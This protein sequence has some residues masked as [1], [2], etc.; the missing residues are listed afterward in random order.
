VFDEDILNIYIDSVG[1]FRQPCPN[2]TFS[3]LWTGLLFAR[4]MYNHS[5]RKI[6][7]ET[8][9]S[10]MAGFSAAPLMDLYVFA[11]CGRR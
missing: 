3:A 4:Y 11:T 6:G 7:D 9:M 5:L 2:K 1:F 8:P 10:G